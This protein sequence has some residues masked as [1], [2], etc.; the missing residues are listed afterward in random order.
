MNKHFSTTNIL[1]DNI[2][3]AKYLCSQGD[4]ATI[5]GNFQCYRKIFAF[6][7]NKF[8]QKL[9]FMISSCKF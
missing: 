3:F 5:L 6:L 9:N 8:R 4:K 1:I 7:A 2:S